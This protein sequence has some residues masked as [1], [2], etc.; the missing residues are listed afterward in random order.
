M[1]TSPSGVPPKFLAAK[2]AI[3]KYSYRNLLDS[4]F[5]DATRGWTKEDR[6]S[7]F[8]WFSAQAKAE[9][10]EKVRQQQAQPAM[11]IPQYVKALM[12]V[13]FSDEDSI[14]QFI[15]STQMLGRQPRP[16]P[17]VL[18]TEKSYKYLLISCLGGLDISSDI[19]EDTEESGAVVEIRSAL[20]NTP[21]Q[22]IVPLGFLQC[23]AHTHRSRSNR[24]SEPM[25][26]PFTIVLNIVDKSLWMVLDK[27]RRDITE[28]DVAI[29]ANA[30]GWD[31]LP[32]PAN[33]RP[34]FDV[35]QILTWRDFTAL[36]Q[37]S[38]E[39]RRFFSKE[40]LA[41]ARRIVPTFWAIAESHVKKALDFQGTSV[42][43]KSG[44]KRSGAMPSKSHKQKA[45]AGPNDGREAQEEAGPSGGQ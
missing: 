1:A 11:T 32:E 12:N 8:E 21:V 35:M 6:K 37:T 28:E 40:A 14:G 3:R 27:Y 16:Q 9:R 17:V 22:Y 24:S 10:E 18:G 2:D 7:F 38:A 23:V 5:E 44:K 45:H 30:N 29:P 20:A 39:A 4:P 13:N 19:A 33:G 41:T 31:F 15:L 36:E 25:N 26:T 43:S 34:S 42:Q